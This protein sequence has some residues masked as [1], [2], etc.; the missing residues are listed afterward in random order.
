MIALAYGAKIEKLKFGHRGSNHPIRNLKTNKVEIAGQNH[1]Y[2][3]NKES[4]EGT[5]LEITHLNVM[6]GTIEGLSCEKDKIFSVQYLPSSYPGNQDGKYLF[7][8]FISNMKE[9]QKNA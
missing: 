7:D 6:D 3:V 8:Q 2:V 1:G 5:G 9:A 4:I